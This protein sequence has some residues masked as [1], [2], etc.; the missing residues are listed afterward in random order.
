MSFMPGPEAEDISDTVWRLKAKWD[1]AELYKVLKHV[2]LFHQVISICKKKK[3][4]DSLLR[5]DDWSEKN[6]NK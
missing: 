3:K 6:K 1:K 2:L 5:L 4:N